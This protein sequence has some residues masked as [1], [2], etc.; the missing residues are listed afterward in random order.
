[1]KA[2]EFRRRKH[3]DL[4][5]PLNLAEQRVRLG[6]EMADAPGVAAEENGGPK[7]LKRLQQ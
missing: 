5:G 3:P 2:I 7:R 1:M 4:F 6:M